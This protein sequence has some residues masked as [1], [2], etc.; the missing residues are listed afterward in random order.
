V[1]YANQLAVPAVWKNVLALVAL[2]K[3][4]IAGVGLGVAALGVVDV[5]HAEIIR[6]FVAE[7]TH[8]RALEVFSATGGGI[9]FVWR[10]IWGFISR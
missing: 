3:A 7:V 6:H 10:L 5:S 2:G 9:G 4:A 1:A 8:N